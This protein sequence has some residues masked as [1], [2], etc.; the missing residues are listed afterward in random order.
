[1]KPEQQKELDKAFNKLVEQRNK[2]YAAGRYWIQGFM[3]YLERSEN[4]PKDG[5]KLKNP[6][7]LYWT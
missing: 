5:H 3:Y 2:D 6:P 4:A 1:M 7:K